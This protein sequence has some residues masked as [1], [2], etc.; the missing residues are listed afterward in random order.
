[1]AKTVRFNLRDKQESETWIYL[2]YRFK[3]N[4]VVIN[5][6]LCVPPKYWNEK[7]QRMKETA[8]YASYKTVNARLDELASITTSLYRDYRAKNTI[9]SRDSFKAALLAIIEK[10]EDQA[11]ELMSFIREFIE[12]R[13]AMNRS[14]SSIKVYT[15]TLN[16]LEAYAKQKRRSLDFKDINEQFKRDFVVYLYSQGFADAYVHKLLSTIR[17]FMRD[18]KERGVTDFEGYRI[19]NIVEKRSAD[20]IYLNEREIDILAKLDLS[21]NPRLDRVRDLFLI[22][23]FTGLRFSD[24]THIKPENIKMEH[25]NGK[26][27]KLLTMT[28]QKTKQRVVLP[29]VHPTLLP[30]LEKYEMKSPPIISNQKLNEYL[31]DLCK[32]A[33]FDESIEINEFIS[34]RHEKK[35]LQKWELVSSHTARRSFA[36]NAYKRGVPIADIMKFT[37]HT[38]VTSFMKYIKVTGEETAIV[39]SD[40]EFFTG[41]TKLRK[42]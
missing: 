42:V 10:R 14:L 41:K 22:G 5:T 9:P 23:C 28:A 6:G 17:T 19:N 29:L 16:H 24:Y 18:A 26:E 20:H 1:M 12:E 8:N 27:V 30:I 7:A 21:E 25:H 36:T 13:R 11:A 32:L 39:L 38:T 4:R 34:G 2:V 31:K 35:I 37:G 3:N 15:T 33:G 40:H